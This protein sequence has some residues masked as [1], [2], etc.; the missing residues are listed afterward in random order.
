MILYYAMGGGLGHLTRARAVL[1]TLKIENES[2]ILTSSSLANDLRIVGNVK[3]IHVPQY[4]EK[5]VA[6]FRLW[7]TDVFENYSVTEIFIDTF[8]LGII[9]ELNEFDFRN[10][11]INYV[12]RLLKWNAYS[13]LISG[14]TPKFQNTFLLEPPEEEHKNFISQHSE[15]TTQL[16]L[17]YPPIEFSDNAKSI[18]KNHSPFWLIIH[19][20]KEEETSELLDYAD[21]MRRIEQSDLSLILIAPNF[22]SPIP[23]KTFHYDFYPASHLF[24]HAERI[25]SGCGFNIMNQ[26]REFRDKHFVIPF[27]RRYDDQYARTSRLFG[28]DFKRAA[29]L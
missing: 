23:S 19:S 9:G 3:I 4:Y 12:A 5:D 13:R 1:H 25:I 22:S 8:P 29:H 15:Q 17:I 20:G 28:K 21:E 11:K 27:P 2:A 18:I 16:E 24:S 26:A 7:L 6:G 10:I 14:N